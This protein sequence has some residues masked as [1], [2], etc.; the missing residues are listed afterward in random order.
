MY[1]Y[2]YICIYMYNKKRKKRKK[3]NKIMYIYIYNHILKMAARIPGLRR[4]ENSRITSLHD[5]VVA[6]TPVRWTRRF[7]RTL[8]EIVRRGVERR[9]S[10]TRPHASSQASRVSISFTTSNTLYIKTMTNISNNAV[11]TY[12]CSSRFICNS[13]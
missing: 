13:I 9:I 3:P 10:A 12:F 1:I 11:Y 5:Y 2:V 7:N 6:K 8:N 4:C